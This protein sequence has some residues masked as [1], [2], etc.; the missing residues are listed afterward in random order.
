[1]KAEERALLFKEILKNI[2]KLE[3]R[4]QDYSGQEEKQ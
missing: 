3:C 2:L 1:M 4:A